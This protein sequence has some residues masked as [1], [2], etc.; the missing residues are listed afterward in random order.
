MAMIGKCSEIDSLKRG[1]DRLYIYT[2]R[3][4]T[5]WEV[6][7]LYVMLSPSLPPRSSAIL[8]IDRMKAIARLCRG[9]PFQLP[10]RIAVF[11]GS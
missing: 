4:G 10:S 11:R 8:L 5:Q 9:L 7:T 6:L 1:S 2:N 3:Q